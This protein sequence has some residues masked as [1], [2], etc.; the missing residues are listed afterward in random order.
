MPHAKETGISFGRLFVRLVCAFTI[1]SYVK[2]QRWHVLHLDVYTV[3]PRFNEVP[4]DWGIVFVISRVRSRT[5]PFNEFF[6]EKSKLFV[7]SRY[8]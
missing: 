5:P 2:L 7:T 6:G 3:E 1:T 8:S 4:R